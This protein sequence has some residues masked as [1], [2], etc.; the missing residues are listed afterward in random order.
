MTKAS[1]MPIADFQSFIEISN[2]D[3]FR[4]CHKWT[5]G[6]RLPSDGAIPSP[7]G[8]DGRRYRISPQ[9]GWLLHLA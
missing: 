1:A 8:L 3:R 5:I 2:S 4:T 6:G 7:D 9:L